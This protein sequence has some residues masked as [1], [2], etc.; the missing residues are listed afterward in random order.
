MFKIIFE[1]I[2]RDLSY[3][4]GLWDCRVLESTSERCSDIIDGLYIQIFYIKA[5]W[6]LFG[7]DLWGGKDL[8]L[9]GGF[10]GFKVVHLPGWC[11]SW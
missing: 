5:A 3:K 7:V 11:G 10:I 1:I 8:E 4:E 9:Q 6:W 2:Y